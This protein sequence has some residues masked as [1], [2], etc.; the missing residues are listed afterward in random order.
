[1][2][3]SLATSGVYAVKHQPWGVPIHI[4]NVKNAPRDSLH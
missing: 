3:L 4:E 1:M 2:T